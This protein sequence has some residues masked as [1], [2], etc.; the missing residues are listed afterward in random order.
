M[1]V[2]C[3]CLSVVGFLGLFCFVVAVL[4]VFAFVVI[5]VVCFDFSV[6]DLGYFCFFAI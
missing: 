1:F 2:C 5:F 4:F 6:C 3:F